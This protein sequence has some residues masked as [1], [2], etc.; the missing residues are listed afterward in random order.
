MRKLASIRVVREIRAIPGA[1]AIEAAKIDGWWL[2][3]KKDEFTV[4]TRCVYCEIDSVLPDKPEFEFLRTKKFTIKT[5]KLRGQ[6]SQGIAFR[7]VDVLPGKYQ[8]MP[9]GTDVTEIIGV[10]HADDI[11]AEKQAAKRKGLARLAPVRRAGMTFPQGV[12]KTDEERVQNLDPLLDKYRGTRF[13]ITEKMDGSSF[14]AFYRDGEFGVCSRNWRLAKPGD[15]AWAKFCNKY[16]VA[17]KVKHV[18]YRFASLFNKYAFKQVRWVRENVFAG[19][20]DLVNI[21]AGVDNNYWDL[22]IQLD[23]E[24]NM[25]KLGFNLAIQ[26]EMCGPGIQGNKYQLQNKHLYVYSMLDLDTGKYVDWTSLVYVCNQIGLETVP[27]ISDNFVLQHSG[28]DLLK[29]A[30]GKSVVYKQVLR[31]GLVFRPWE[32]TYDSEI[33]GL[34]HSFVSFKAVSNKWLEAFDKA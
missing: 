18:E 4:G 30:D 7:V 31:E 25:R 20:L 3:V 5:I 16:Q 19:L 2:V 17:K 28:E 24:A 8:N 32:V 14:T 27:L 11:K 33:A 15:T 1:D 6:I 12:P 9:E 23:L 26:G 13:Y 21:D 34:N 10:R 29:M 22:A